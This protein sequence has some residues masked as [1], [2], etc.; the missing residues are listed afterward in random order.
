[1]AINISLIITFPYFLWGLELK[2]TAFTRYNFNIVTVNAIGSN[3]DREEGGGSPP[4]L[5]LV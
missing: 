5:S 1:M 2:L 3:L 4:I